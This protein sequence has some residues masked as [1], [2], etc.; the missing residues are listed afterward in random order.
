MRVSA[1]EKRRLNRLHEESAALLEL[2]AGRLP[3]RDL[4]QLRTLSRVG[5]WAELV[6]SLSAVLV[7][8]QIAVTPGERDALA[9]VLEMFSRPSESFY[10]YIDDSERTLT[11][12]NI[13]R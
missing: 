2:L 12:L 5:E 9:G 4:W 10:T 1:E 6:N 11:A 13:V 3:E 8:R 7:A